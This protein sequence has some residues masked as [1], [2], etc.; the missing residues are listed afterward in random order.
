M[1]RLLLLTILL[2]FV[3]C[4]QEGKKHHDNHDEHSH[5]HEMSTE[6]SFKFGTWITSEKDKSN[7]DYAAEFKKYK[8]GGIDEVLINTL[9]DPKELERLT[10]IAAKEGLK[11]HAW[12]MAVNR[13]GDTVAL[14]HPEWYMVSKEG[15]SCFD[16]RPY[17]G[18]YQWLCPTRKESRNHILG[19]VEGLAKVE[20]VESVHLD[21]IRFPDIFLPIGLLPK[22]DLVQDH[23]MPEYDFCYCDVCIS[24]FEKMHHKNPLESKNTANDMEWKNF[25]LNAQLEY[26]HGGHIS[27]E[28][29]N[30]LVSKGVT[31]D[32]ENRSTTYIIPAVLADRFGNVILDDE[33]NTIQNNFQYSASDVIA[34]SAFNRIGEL[35]ILDASVVRLRELSLHYDLP[36]SKLK[37][38]PFK[39]A[40]I[41]LAGRNLWYYAPY[42]PKYANYDPESAGG[43]GGFG[44]PSSKQFSIG[45]SATF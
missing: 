11:V 22:Y 16:T 20:G 34:S 29:V 5:D 18:Y 42:M 2:V 21:Y 33:G 35:S 45:F 38:F 23:E 44:V 7:E 3:A 8:S 26:R 10:P 13:P 36:V 24:E 32:T 27:S 28:A 6:S 30:A 25:R 9:T 15:K 12:I 1:K 17:V 19:L 4:N 37:K 39:T 31:R 43:G 14:K 40:S 41:T